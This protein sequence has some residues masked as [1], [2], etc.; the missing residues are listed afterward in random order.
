MKDIIDEIR[1]DFL[2]RKQNTPFKDFAP[3]ASGFLLIT[4][5]IGV[6]S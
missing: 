6:K 1:N 2:K 3:Q 4:R 5:Y